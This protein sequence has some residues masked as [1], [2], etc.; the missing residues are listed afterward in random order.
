MGQIR[1]LS[2]SIRLDLDLPP[3]SGSAMLEIKNTGYEISGSTI[4]RGINLRVERG[5][6]LAIVGPNGA[7]KTTLLRLLSSDLRPTS[8]DILLDGIGVQ[9]YPARKLA[10]KRAVMAQNAQIT[11][12]F[13]VYEVAMMG[14]FPHGGSHEDEQIVLDAL[15]RTESDHLR[16]RLYPT[17]SGG[18]QARVTLAR[19]LAQRTP[20]L[21]LDEPTSALDLRHQQIVMRIARDL[22]ANGAAVILILHDLNLAATHADRVGMLHQGAL[23][24]EGKPHDVLTA[25]NIEAVFNLPVHVMPHPNAPNGDCPLIVPLE[26]NH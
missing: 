6:V 11:F 20:L 17:L 18:E 5:E 23:Y 19:V 15:Q 3:E 22:A 13:T 4:L 10:L 21:L 24:A 2:D 9:H 12:E 25:E 7:G 14:R 1:N 8:G 16:E 26:P